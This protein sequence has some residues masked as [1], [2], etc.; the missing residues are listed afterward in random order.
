MASKVKVLKTEL[1]A[2]NLWDRLYAEDPKPSL[3]DKQACVT[4]FFRRAQIAVELM[5]LTASN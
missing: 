4:R 1:E 2:I 3:I 5:N